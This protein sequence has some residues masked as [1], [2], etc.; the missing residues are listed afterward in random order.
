[1]K[2]ILLVIFVC[3]FALLVSSCGNKKQEGH[4]GVHTHADGTV[5]DGGHKQEEQAKPEQ[6]SFEVD[7][8][9]TEVHEHDHDHDHQH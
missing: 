4:S 9:S 6:E 5:H 2:K 3:A 7:V 1:M 8:D